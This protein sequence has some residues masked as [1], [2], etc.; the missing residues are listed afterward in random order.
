[1]ITVIKILGQDES[2]PTRPLIWAPTEK[3]QCHISQSTDAL[4]CI[5]LSTPSSSLQTLHA[6]IIPYILKNRKQERRR[7]DK[8]AW[9]RRK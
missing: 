4:S 6:Y 5:T 9:N 7:E 8:K 2:R 3:L 1:M